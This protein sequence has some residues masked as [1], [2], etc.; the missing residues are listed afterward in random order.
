MPYTRTSTALSHF[1]NLNI[2]FTLQI[3]T[4]YNCMGKNKCL[5]LA[6]FSRVFTVW[7]AMNP[8]LSWNLS[9]LVAQTYIRSFSQPCSLRSLAF[10]AYRLHSPMILATKACVHS[11]FQLCRLS[12]P[13]FQALQIEFIHV[14]KFLAHAHLVACFYLF[15]HPMTCSQLCSLF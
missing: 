6:V 11:C 1:K 7:P 12:S 9:S 4:W 3:K 15:C 2:Y 5:C 8:G 14:Y 13:V 10:S